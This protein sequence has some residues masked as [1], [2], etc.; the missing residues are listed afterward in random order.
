MPKIIPKHDLFL[1]YISTAKYIIIPQKKAPKNNDIDGVNI[2]TLAAAIAIKAGLNP[3]KV[4]PNSHPA[5]KFVIIMGSI[6]FLFSFESNIYPAL[7]VNKFNFNAHT[8]NNPKENNIAP[9]IPPIV[10]L[11]QTPKE[12]KIAAAIDFLI[13]SISKL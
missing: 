10:K 2:V 4:A 1:L 9:V 5:I 8:P 3:D 11:M 13:N 6:S 12:I 7:P